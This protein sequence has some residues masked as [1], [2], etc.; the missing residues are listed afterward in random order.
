MGLKELLK[1]TIG[2]NKPRVPFLLESLLY[3][4]E[5]FKTDVAQGVTPQLSLDTSMKILEVG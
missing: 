1:N 4:G 3:L 2:F 5:V